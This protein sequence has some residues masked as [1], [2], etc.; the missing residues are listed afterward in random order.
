MGRWDSIPTCESL[1]LKSHTPTETKIYINLSATQLTSPY[2]T[3][4]TTLHE[5]PKRFEE[6][7]LRLVD[8]QIIEHDGFN[9][10]KSAENATSW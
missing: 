10:Y 8:R 6:P 9:P 5:P 3:S 7:F 2:I 4:V 1:I